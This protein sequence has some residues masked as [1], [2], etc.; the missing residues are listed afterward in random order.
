MAER[1]FKFSSPGIFLKEVDNSHLPALPLA[2]GP[3]II[4]RTQKGPGMVPLT[5]SSFSDFVEV[6]G[7]PVA[8][9]GG[10]DQWRDGNTTGPT[11]ASYA[12]QAYLR[13][14]G[15]VTM[16][17]LLGENA[18][19]ATGA[20]LAGWQTRDSAGDANTLDTSGGGAYGLFIADS[21]SVNNGVKA[22]AT[23]TVADGDD[24]TNGQFTE[25]EY[26][27][28]TSINGVKRV[29]VLCDG[30]E[31]MSVTTGDI[32]TAA[33]D[34]GAAVLGSTVGDLGTCIGVVNNL[35]THNQ[36]TVL[37]EI[38][39]AILSVN[40]HNG[41]VACS[42][43]L[44]PA[45]GEQTITLTQLRSGTEGNTATTTNISQITAA[46]FASGTNHSQ[47]NLTGTLAAIFYAGVGSIALSGTR[48]DGT[49]NKAEAASFIK[50]VT[51][52]Q[53]TFVL[54]VS[55]SAA[56]AKGIEFNFDPN[57]KK[58]VRKVFNTNP[59]LTNHEVVTD[60]KYY[61]LGETFE[62]DVKT[63]CTTSEQ[64]GIVLGLKASG[65]TEE[66]SVHIYSRH[67]AKTPWVVGQHVGNASDFSNTFANVQ[68][69]FRLVSLNGG[70]WPAKNLKV[71]VQDI[72]ASRSPYDPYGTFSVLIRRVSDLDASPQV[73]ERYTQCNLNPN[74]ENY[75]CKK[76][77]DRFLQFVEPENALR[78]I[79]DY[80]NRSNYFRV[81]VDE[82]VKRGASP[83]LIPFGFYG[84]PRFKGLSIVSGAAAPRTL[85]STATAESSPFVVGSGSVPNYKTFATGDTQ[86][87]FAYINSVAG[88]TA[89]FQ[90]PTLPLRLSS[91]E[92]GVSVSKP[93]NTYWGITTT[94]TGTDTRFNESY[95]DIMRSSPQGISG[96][97]KSVADT[98]WQEYS[99]YFTL[100]N[101]VAHADNN[102]SGA[103][104][105]VY[106][107]GSRKLGT[108]LTAV[109][110]V[111]GALDNGF[112][113]FTIPVI[114]GA[115]GLNILQPEPFGNH[116]LTAASTEKNNYAY[117]T[118]KRA[119]DTIE[120]P[121]DVEMNILAVPGIRNAKLTRRMIDI[122]EK[123]TDSL[124][125]IDLLN[126]YTPST[127]STLSEADRIGS[128]SSTISGLESRA[129]N[130]SYACTYYPWIQIRD[131][132]SG[133]N[134][135][136]PPSVVALG[137]M[138][139]SE[140]RSELWFAPAGFNRGGL[141]LGAAGIPVIGVRQRLTS[142]ERDKLYEKNINP[143]ASFPAE[144][145]VIFGQKTMQVTPS[146]LDR[147]NVRRLMIYVKREVSRMAKRI[148]FDQNVNATWA[149]FLGQV[150]PF[151]TN[152][153]IRFGLTDFLVLLDETTTTPD[154]IDRNI[155]YAKVFLKPAR[156]IEFIALD[157]VIT[158]TGA[159]FLE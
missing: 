64:V 51:G 108:S 19:G 47:Q 4:G 151:L 95:G 90:F 32:I 55:S 7:E 62:N 36:A 100:D 2:V 33:T 107:A 154:M 86:S 145:I 71:S 148:L 129:I 12:A 99:F 84:P 124:A 18:A 101:L 29:Y 24:A 5:V 146:A 141:S 159:D 144:G 13:N 14:N 76:V 97:D 83:D 9:V 91:K 66:Q 115:D 150:N 31:T 140:T 48:I 87:N 93:E 153:K 85:D 77:G 117:Y 80:P 155:L 103:T 121:E 135:W 68:K 94:L 118:V 61:W 110:G 102:S 6:F 44:T 70:A 54:Q 1:Q 46:D 11:Y 39:V 88:F 40:G 123:R 130:S 52:K 79:G 114:G 149:R 78:A 37:N 74:S 35:N 89:K 134:L 157:F 56:G 22:T 60:K 126:D 104:H 132:L 28:I 127:E 75:I 15:P 106:T 112:D 81:E 53:N 152:V 111:T 113:R 25:G 156:S 49:E 136:V 120:D 73:I 59:T 72:R 38:R 82:Q 45:D 142:K 3:V 17:R 57:D 21:G 69:L 139:S 42:A 109:G 10:G 8:G 23:L 119:L 63:R 105:A 158:N 20:G 116:V 143:I 96:A 125:I 147:I 34:I 65:S 133:N 27:I 30:S 122:C 67:D 58:F 98:S 137:V 138:G 92:E 131:F 128:V 16:I 50:S 43:A 41:E 26:V